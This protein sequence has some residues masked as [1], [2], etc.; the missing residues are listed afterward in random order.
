MNGCTAV[1]GDPLDLERF[2]EEPGHPTEL[3]EVPVVTGD[4]ALVVMEAIQRARQM[5]TGVISLRG[6]M[7]DAPVVKRAARILRTAR[8]FGLIDYELS[9]EV[10]HGKE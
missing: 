8:A 6:K 4:D 5:G 9:D 7:L 2:Y 10:I 1:A 3:D